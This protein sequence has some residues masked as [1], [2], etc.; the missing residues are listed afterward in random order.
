MIEISKE[1]KKKAVEALQEIRPKFSG[2]NNNFAKQWGFTGSVWSRMRSGEVDGLIKDSLWLHI[3]RELDVTTGKQKLKPARTDVFQII[4]EDVLFCKENAKSRMFVDEPEIGKT[5]ALKYLAK[6]LPNCFYIDASQSKTQQLFVRALAKAI[7]LDN[8]GTYN[9]LKGY[10][11][12]YLKILPQ[13]IVLI[14]EAGDLNENSFLDL[15]E[16]WNATEGCCAFYLAGA[17]GLLE[18]IKR[19]IEHKKVGFRELYSRFG[20]SYTSIVPTGKQEKKAF[21]MK[22]IDD[23]LTHNLED[24]TIIPQIIKKCITEDKDANI[25]GLRRLES[26]LIL[27]K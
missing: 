19:C 26:I 13:P 2:S 20:S 25:G 1:L 16:Y 15:K 9:D 10:I 27:N 24:K 4:E 22:L 21:Y 17:E 3:C 14:D 11:K 8:R 6:T 5:V 18:K 23:V 7:G 12:A